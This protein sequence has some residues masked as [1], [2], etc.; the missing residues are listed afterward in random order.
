MN[1]LPTC[2]LMKADIVIFYPTYMYNV[3]SINVI[4]IRFCD[5]KI[6][7]AV[8]VKTVHCVYMIVRT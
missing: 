2:K 8:K 6:M 7:V 3:L 5:A 1:L 4:I